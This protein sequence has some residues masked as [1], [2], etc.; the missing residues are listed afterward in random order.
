MQTIEAMALPFAISPVFYACSNL[1]SFLVVREHVR[2]HW[3]VV[4]LFAV[5]EAI[6]QVFLR[7]VHWM[8]NI[9]L[10]YLCLFLYTKV[11]DVQPTKLLYLSLIIVSVQVISN[12]IVYLITG[13]SYT[14]TWDDMWIVLAVFSVMTAATYVLLRRV[15]WP[16][17]KR[18]NLSKIPWLWLI[19][20]H[21]HHDQPAAQLLPHPIAAQCR[22]APALQS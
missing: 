17:L 3:S 9:P 11:T 8:L 4:I 22:N 15:V 14:W 10:V 20:R 7:S 21:L 1:L 13:S 16:M 5:V 2:I 19:P 12:D 18:M 6:L